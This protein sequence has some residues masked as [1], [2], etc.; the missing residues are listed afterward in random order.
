MSSSRFKM[1]IS[2]QIAKAEF[3]MQCAV[4][5]TS[6]RLA[7]IRSIKQTLSVSTSLFVSSNNW[8]VLYSQDTFLTMY[9][10]WCPTGISW[11]KEYFKQWTLAWKSDPRWPLTKKPFTLWHGHLII[12]LHCLPSEILT[13][14]YVA[15]I[16]KQFWRKTKDFVSG[17]V[18]KTWRMFCC[19]DIYQQPSRRCVIELDCNTYVICLPWPPGSDPRWCTALYLCNFS[20]T[21]VTFFGESTRHSTSPHPRLLL[22]GL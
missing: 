20:L 1:D 13:G 4:F 19:L 6:I 10:N 2:L 17:V 14:T 22:H 3:A 18:P 5:Q 12:P 15:N 16:I 21:H 7:I 11:A 9:N 8:N